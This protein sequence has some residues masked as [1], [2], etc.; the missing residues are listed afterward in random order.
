M[1]IGIV[2]TGNMGRVLGGLWAVGGH[3]VFFGARRAEASEKAASLARAQRLAARATGG[4]S[5]PKQN[6]G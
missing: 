1:K 3:E 5:T 6:G 4:P 2:G